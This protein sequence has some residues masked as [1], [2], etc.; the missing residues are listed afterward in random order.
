MNKTYEYFKKRER[1]HQKKQLKRDEKFNE[2]I[3][4]EYKKT[5]KEIQN[6]MD[7]WIGKYADDNEI[8]IDFAKEIISKTDINDYKEL[9]KEYVKNKD[10]SP[11]ANREMRIY[12]LKMKMARDELLQKYIDLE[13]GKLGTKAEDI[14]EEHIYQEVEEELIRQAGILGKDLIDKDRIE[15]VTK[16]LTTQSHNTTHFSEYLWTDI[17]ELRNHL[18]NGLNR[19]LLRGEHPMTWKNEL[20]RHYDKRF[21]SAEYAARRLA[22]TETAIAQNN[23]AIDTIKDNGY[24]EVIVITELNACPLCKPHDG[25]IVKID[26]A[27]PGDNIPIWHPNCRCTVAAYYDYA[28][29]KSNMKIKSYGAHNEYGALNEVND[30]KGEKREIHAKKYYESIRKR[31]A[32]REIKRVFNNVK[33]EGFKEEDIEIV[34]NHIFIKKHYLRVE[35][36]DEFAYMNF[37]PSYDMAES[38]RRLSTGQ[39]IQ[40]HDIILL[41][42]ELMESTI[43]ETKK[44]YYPEAHDITN[45][46]YNYSYEL[47]KWLKENKEREK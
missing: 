3:T 12:N 24:D 42:H 40:H 26:E 4:K 28:N 27:K 2:I 18:E 29:D 8:T 22:M 10:L 34:F 47:K 23:I 46:K 9:A 25:S 35:G 6:R 33:D 17:K 39:N 30:P 16:Y 43:M 14:I 15:K 11:R 32:E 13:L 1:E 20:K 36:K 41:K 31:N 7:W 21:G 37:D 44:I 45:K 5:Y 38:W 19:T